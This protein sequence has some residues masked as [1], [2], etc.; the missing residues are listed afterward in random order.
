MAAIKLVVPTLGESITE[1]VVSKWLK[2]VG[3]SFAVDEPLVDLETDKVS[4]SV[5][6]PSAGVLT[7][8]AHAAGATVKIGDVLGAITPGPAP[9]KAAGAAPSP[10]PVPSSPAQS[11]PQSQSALSNGGHSATGSRTMPPSVR[12][13]I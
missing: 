9:A 4:V 6:A 13:A 2:N 1:A 7:E 8:Q 3:D 10:A 5:N 12:K 11:Q